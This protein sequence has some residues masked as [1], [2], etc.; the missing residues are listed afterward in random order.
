MLSIQQKIPEI[1]VRTSN[2]TGHLGSVRPEYSGP[3]LKVVHFD[4]NFK[5][6]FLLNWK[7]PRT[8]N[9]VAVATSFYAKQLRH[10]SLLLLSVKDLPTAAPL[11]RPQVTRTSIMIAGSIRG[12]SKKLGHKSPLMS[13]TKELSTYSRSSA[14]ATPHSTSSSK[15]T[16]LSAYSTTKLLR[17]ATSSPLS[18]RVAGDTGKLASSVATATSKDKR[19]N[20]RSITGAIGTR[21]YAQHLLA[22]PCGICKKPLYV[23]VT[24]PISYFG[25]LKCLNLGRFSISFVS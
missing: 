4:R 11:E 1:S 16:F 21:F 20:G 25:L 15:E 19:I 17:K 13:S 12:T 9:I 22:V 6:K 10:T 5:P 2:G 8:A 7:R 18:S 14:M 24:V 3:A 23:C